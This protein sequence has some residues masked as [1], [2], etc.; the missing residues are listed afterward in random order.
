MAKKLKTIEQ[1]K[2]EIEMLQKSYDEQKATEANAIGEFIQRTYNVD[3]L[4]EFRGAYE[5]RKIE[6]KEV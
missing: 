4:A 2:A 1:L 5:V 3:S 6:N